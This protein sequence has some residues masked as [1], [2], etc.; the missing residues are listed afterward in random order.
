MKK[1]LTKEELIKKLEQEDINVGKNA[2]TTLNS[3]VRFNLLPHPIRIGTEDGTQGFYPPILIDIVQD[4]S[5]WKATMKYAGIRE[6]LHE[7]YPEVFALHDVVHLFRLHFLSTAVLLAYMDKVEFR[8]EWRTKIIQLNEQQ[9]EYQ[10]VK[11]Q[12]LEFLLQVQKS[13]REGS[14]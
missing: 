11:K 13:D 8:E 2:G 5:T 6:R 7:K 9:A 4:I 12:L 14:E 3:Y 1:A 10:D